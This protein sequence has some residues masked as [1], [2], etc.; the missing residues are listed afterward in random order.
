MAMNPAI[1][2]FNNHEPGKIFFFVKDFRQ[3]AMA[4]FKKKRL[5]D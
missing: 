4:V 3:R 5:N 2:R 1:P